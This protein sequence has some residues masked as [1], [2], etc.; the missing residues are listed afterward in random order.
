VTMFN[1]VACLYERGPLMRTVLFV[2][3]AV[4]I[5]GS[6]RAALAVY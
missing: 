2:S 3:V 4:E 6:S 1:L 5:W